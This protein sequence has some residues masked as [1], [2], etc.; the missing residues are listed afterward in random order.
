MQEKLSTFF[1]LRSAR[2]A[3]E[4]L[5]DGT[6]DALEMKFQF[7]VSFANFFEYAERVKCDLS[8]SRHTRNIG[9]RPL[10]VK[11]FF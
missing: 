9:P 4:K 3:L 10:K 1:A 5:H 11:H 2:F 6:L 7:E 8:G